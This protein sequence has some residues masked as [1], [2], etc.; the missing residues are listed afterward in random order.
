MENIIYFKNKDSYW[1][2]SFLDD[3]SPDDPRRIEEPAGKMVFKERKDYSLGDEQTESFADFFASQL[4][5]EKEFYKGKV[6]VTIPTLDKAMENPMLSKYIAGN[7]EIGHHFDIEQ[8][9]QHMDSLLNDLYNALGQG[10]CDEITGGI[11]FDPKTGKYS[12]CYEIEFSTADSKHNEDISAA[13]YT[14]VRELGN[15]LA[16]YFDF[17][18]GTDYEVQ[19]S[20]ENDLSV[21]S[22]SQLYDRW[23]ASK[24]AVLPI[25]LYIHSG[26]TCHEASARKTLRANNDRDDGYIYNDG[27]VY[28]DK[29][30]EDFLACI[31]KEKISDESYVRDQAEKELSSEIKEYASY[32]E[33]DVHV[34]L[35]EEFDKEKLDWTYSE[36]E[37]PY[38]GSSLPE[39]LKDHGF[40]LNEILSEKEAGNLRETVTEEFRKATWDKY[41]SNVRDA[42]PEFDNKVEYASGAVLYAMKKNDS[43]GLARKALG[44]Y[45]NQ[46][47]CTSKEKTI[48]FLNEALG[49]SGKGQEKSA[50]IPLNDKSIECVWSKVRNQERSDNGGCDRM[51]LI[52]YEKK[53]FALL[54]GVSYAISNPSDT[55]YKKTELLKSG[56]AVEKKAGELLKAGFKNTRVSGDYLEQYRRNDKWIEKYI[57]KERER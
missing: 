57:L 28:I 12:G 41:L 31:D 19:T 2:A 56:K 24:L 45:M 8:F 15:Y 11:P 13:S 38:Y 5:P 48:A 4:E 17:K 47:G 22:E 6:S 50:V 1:K 42:L 18:K 51:L 49:I 3:N 21:L 27:F 46:N 43:Q 55:Y 25:D 54:T 36:R 34:L 14:I 37:G 23:A 16:D 20:L 32:L 52:D 26:I 29:D 30:D 44:E 7:D 53:K 39:V 40:I 9:N 10:F 33:E 35:L